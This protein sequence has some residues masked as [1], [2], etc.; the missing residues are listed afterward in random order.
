MLFPGDISSSAE[1]RP[2]I[3]PANS[4]KEERSDIQRKRRSELTGTELSFPVHV[5]LKNATEEH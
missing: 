2:R 3:S 5:G 4:S 1:E